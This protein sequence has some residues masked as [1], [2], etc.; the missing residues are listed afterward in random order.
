MVVPPRGP[1]GIVRRLINAAMGKKADAPPATRPGAKA[2]G[3][4]GAG[5]LNPK[6]LGEGTRV[7][8]MMWCRGASLVVLLLSFLGAICYASSRV[9]FVEDVLPQISG[10]IR[11]VRRD[12]AS[13]TLGR[14]RAHVPNKPFDLSSK[15]YKPQTLNP[16]P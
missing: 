16:L 1:R 10:A 13:R 4:S 8:L 3:S 7:E 12:P 11:P 15:P 14:P 6:P 9:R 5:S 2:Q